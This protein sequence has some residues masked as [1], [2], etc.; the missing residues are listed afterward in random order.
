M[1]KINYVAYNRE[2]NNFIKSGVVSRKLEEL[3]KYHIDLVASFDNF[4]F[5]LYHED[6]KGK[7]LSFLKKYSNCFKSENGHT[8]FCFCSE[9]IFRAFLQVIREKNKNLTKSERSKQQKL[10]ATL[11]VE[12]DYEPKTLSWGELGKLISKMTPK[13]KKQTVEITESGHDTLGKSLAF[14]KQGNPYI[15]GF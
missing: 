15:R 8:V 5:Y 9:I 13:Q 12:D 10:L 7:A 2:F 6:M 11:K 1:K 4:K 14:D 3:F